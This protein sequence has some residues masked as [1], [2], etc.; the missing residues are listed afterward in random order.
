M[1]HSP[2]RSSRSLGSSLV[3]GLARR[4]RS[5]SQK[6]GA[7]M[8]R[9]GGQSSLIRLS[10]PHAAAPTQGDIEAQAHKLAEWMRQRRAQGLESV[11]L[12]SEFTHS[13]LPL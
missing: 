12:Q 10:Q 9:M 1:A 7:V 5:L 2:A 3:G 13:V 4:S 8:R 6:A 11:F